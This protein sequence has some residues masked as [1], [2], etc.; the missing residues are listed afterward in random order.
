MKRQ[1]EDCTLACSKEEC[2]FT[3]AK[4]LNSAARVVLD[5]ILHKSAY[6]HYCSLERV[7]G[8][9]IQKR[10]YLSKCSSKKMNDLQEPVK[11]A[12]ETNALKRTFIMCL[13]HSLSENAAMWGLYGKSNPFA[14]RVTIPGQVLED[15]MKRIE[16]KEVT[17][18]D[19]EKIKKAIR[20]M[21][22]KD[23]NGRPLSKGKI[24]S[25][26]FRDV[27]Y[28]SV[29]GE[30][31]RDEYDIRRGNRVSWEKAYY[32]LK[33]RD[34]A[35]DGQY[36]GFIK[37]CEWWHEQESRLCIRLKKEVEDDCISI[38]VPKEVIASMRFTFSPWLKPSHEKH[39]RQILEMALN[40]AGVDVHETTN[41]QR[42]RRSVLQGALNFR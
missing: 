25:S 38:A 17:R 3:K 16:I 9:I 15:W 35:I 31:K 30:K 36:A 2:R 19:T 20:A 41:S 14:L 13:G 32:N 11:F 10:W 1:C 34:C 6:Q 29:A 27:L 22:A 33:D 24:Q 4:T 18:F 40:G 39:V 8:K 5:G 23:T 28:A 42:F 7:L 12:G 37:D 21:E 26:V